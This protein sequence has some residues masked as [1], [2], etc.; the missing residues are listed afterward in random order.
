VLPGAVDRRF[1][2]QGHSSVVEIADARRLAIRGTRA[3]SLGQW[4]AAESFRARGVTP[5]SVAP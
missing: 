4:G 5:W 1:V 3:R 2:G